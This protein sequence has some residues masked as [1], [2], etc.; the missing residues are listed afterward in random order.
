MNKHAAFMFGNFAIAAGN[1]AVLMANEGC[2]TVL[3]FVAGACTMGGIYEMT[4]WLL[5][6]YAEQKE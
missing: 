5:E 2:G 6:V 3:A 1:A 4:E